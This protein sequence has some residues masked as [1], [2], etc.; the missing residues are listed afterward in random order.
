M[1]KKITNGVYHCE[2]TTQFKNSVIDWLGEDVSHKLDRLGVVE[3][4]CYPCIIVLYW[5]WRG[6][7]YIGVKDI[8]TVELKEIL[9][10]L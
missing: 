6:Y 4:T 5:G 2:N 3:P 7:N 1:V 10:G 9:N 8:H